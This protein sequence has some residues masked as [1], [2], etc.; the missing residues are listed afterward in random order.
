MAKFAADV[1][2]DAPLDKIATST[3]QT[4]CSAQPANFAGIA[5]VALADAVLAPGDFTKDDYDDG[6][7]VTGRR[8]TVAAKTGETV[9]TGGE[10]THIAL[11]DGTTLL[12]VTLATAQ[13]LTAGNPV[14]FPA[15]SVR[16]RDPV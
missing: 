11:D 16:F 10:A 8:V 5:A 2:L 13:V 6:G 3:R 9:D 4:A 7:G 15:W 1:V 14:N 12:Y